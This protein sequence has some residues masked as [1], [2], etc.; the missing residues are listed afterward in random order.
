MSDSPATQ[1]ADPRRPDEAWGKSPASK[2]DNGDYDKQSKGH[3][4]LADAKTDDRRMEPARDDKNSEKNAPH[5]D[6]EEQSNAP[7]KPPIYKRPLFWVIAAI[8]IVIGSIVGILWWLHARAHETTDD[9]FIQAMWSRVSPQVA[10][11]VLDRY[12]DDN[13]MGESRRSD[14][15]DRS[16]GFPGPAQQAEA[17]LQAAAGSTSSGEEARC[18]STQAQVAQAKADVIAA[19]A[20]SRQAAADLQRYQ[21]VQAAAISQQQLDAARANARTTRANLEAARQK[22]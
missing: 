1:W 3:D 15:E 5:G 7:K 12:V 11:H 2:P 22:Q 13:Q 19:E 18:R 9:A 14:G 10:G 17:D 21:N 20:S 6:A 16:A 8:V 4:N